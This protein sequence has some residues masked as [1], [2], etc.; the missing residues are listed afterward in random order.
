MIKQALVGIAVIAFSTNAIAETKVYSS[1]PP[2]GLQ[3]DA[4]INTPANSPSSEF[5]GESQFGRVVITDD[6]LGTV[7]LDEFIDTSS[8]TPLDLDLSTALGPGAF[9]FNA[10]TTTTSPTPGQTG[11]GSTAAGTGSITW[12]VISGWTN[13]G[14]QFCIS[15]PT[16]VCNS[17]STPHGVTTEADDVPSSTYDLGTWSFD[18]EGNY[19]ASPLIGSTLSGGTSNI[20]LLYR[21]RLVGPALPALPLLGM[22]ALGL[23]LLS[24][25]ARSSLQKK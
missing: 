6:G 11:T 5:F 10:P 1:N 14:F 4:I 19:E 20:V 17:T 15:S 7:T 9:V 23:A 8:P 3:G 16:T 24:L 18:A 2:G 12:G 21:G 25:G 22:G 13:T